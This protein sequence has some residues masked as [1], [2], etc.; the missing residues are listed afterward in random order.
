MK[1]LIIDNFDSFT[2]NLVQIVEQCGVDDYSIVTHDRINLNSVGDFD[3]I[4]ITPGPG[5]PH[6]HPLLESVIKQ[7]YKSKSVL[8]ICLGHQAIAHTFGA[9]IFNQNVVAH[10]VTKKIIINDS[11]DYLFKDLPNEFSVGLYH[12]WAVSKADFPDELKVTAVSEDGVIMALSHKQYDVKGVQF[13]PESIMTWLGK[14]ILINWI[15]K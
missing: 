14:Q 13:H 1:L 15:E 5:L 7:Y 3:K 4:L 6:E 8:G 9:R 11:Q 2:Y 12:S 10:G